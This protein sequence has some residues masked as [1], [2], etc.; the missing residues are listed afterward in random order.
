MNNKKIEV[1]SDLF[2]F[3]AFFLYME[4]TDAGFQCLIIPLTERETHHN[5]A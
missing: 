3:N 5:N 4:E 2:R 1:I